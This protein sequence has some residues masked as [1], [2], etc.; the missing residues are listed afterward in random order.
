MGRREVIWPENSLSFFDVLFGSRNT[1]LWLWFQVLHDRVNTVMLFHDQTWWNGSIWELTAPLIHMSVVQITNEI[2]L[3]RIVEKFM[4][5]VRSIS[6]VNNSFQII[7][8]QGLQFIIFRY[9][10]LFIK[11]TLPVA[12]Y[13]LISRVTF[14]RGNLLSLRF[15]LV[16]LR[17]LL[18]L[19]SYYA[20]NNSCRNHNSK[21]QNKG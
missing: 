17:N 12:L 4:L 9:K 21:Y 6:W 13:L 5:I 15:F 2:K 11:I 10:R 3:L 20:H 8:F 14:S 19:D 18:F 7:F 1:K 16:D